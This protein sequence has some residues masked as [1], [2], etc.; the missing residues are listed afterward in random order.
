M[1][2]NPQGFDEAPTNAIADKIKAALG[3]SVHSNLRSMIS[4]EIGKAAGRYATTETRRLQAE[5]RRLR[6]ANG[7]GTLPSVSMKA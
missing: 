6:L 7:G 4:I 5:K 3:I 2:N 1:T